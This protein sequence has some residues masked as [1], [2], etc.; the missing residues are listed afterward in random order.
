M[1]KFLKKIAAIMLAAIII[2][3]ASVTDTYASS[4]VSVT[5]GDDVKGG[6]VFSVYTWCGADLY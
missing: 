2:I 1:K 4:T 5:G 3:P 6:E